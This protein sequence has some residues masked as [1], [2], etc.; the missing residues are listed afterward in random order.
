MILRSHVVRSSSHV[1]IF[2]WCAKTLG[3]FEMVSAI[4][5]ILL[6]YCLLFIS[7]CFSS[8]LYIRPHGKAASDFGMREPR[9]TSQTRRVS[10]GLLSFRGTE[11]LFVLVGQ[12]ANL[13]MT[14]V[15]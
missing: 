9:E 5:T 6:N 1:Q 11:R 8:S 15:F 2:S 10:V 14:Y 4:T 3:C 7:F 12:E 13:F